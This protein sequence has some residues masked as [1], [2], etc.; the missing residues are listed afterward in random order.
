MAY[1]LTNKKISETFSYIMQRRGDDNRLYDL[2]G[3]EIGD[4]SFSGSSDFGNVGTDNHRFTG[5]LL[6]N[7]HITFDSSTRFIGMKNDTNLLQLNIGAFVINGEVTA[8]GN[9]SSSS[10][11]TGSFGTLRLDINN[12]PTSDPSVKGAVWRDGTDLK[13]SAG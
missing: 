12:L 9:I 5:S 13:I 8:S 10:T 1:D 4:L 11:S 6:M 2:K 7:G 3:N